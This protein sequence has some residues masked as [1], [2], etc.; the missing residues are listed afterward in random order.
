[1]DLNPLTQSSLLQIMDVGRWISEK[2]A[3]VQWQ[4]S[5]VPFGILVSS[6]LSRFASFRKYRRTRSSKCEM[7][8]AFI[9]KI[10]K[11]KWSCLLTLV[12]HQ[13]KAMTIA[14][15]DWRT[16]HHRKFVFA[17][18]ILKTFVWHR[19]LVFPR[20]SMTHAWQLFCEKSMKGLEGC[21]DMI[22]GIN[23]T[24]FVKKISF[25]AEI[26]N[27]VESGHTSLAI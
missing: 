3:D 17:S 16:R 20:A 14:T 22:R 2:A 4:F 27:A 8:F 15:P 1:M 26:L 19:K 6:R 25:S 18:A 24:N 10:E 23:W 21:A 12:S 13:A 9:I 5:T 7:L 11:S